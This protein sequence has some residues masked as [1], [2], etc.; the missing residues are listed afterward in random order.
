MV[1]SGSIRFMAVTKYLDV[2]PL[3]SPVV[4]KMEVKDCLSLIH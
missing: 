4:S 1:A 2:F 3:P